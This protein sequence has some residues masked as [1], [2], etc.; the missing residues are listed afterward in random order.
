MEKD[1]G[2]DQSDIN[3]DEKWSDPKGKW[4]IEPTGFADGLES[5]ITPIF[6]SNQPKE[7]SL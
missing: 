4:N 2:L 7:L 5:N 3:G 1:A 6:W